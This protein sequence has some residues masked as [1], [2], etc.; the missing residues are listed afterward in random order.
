MGH[1]WEVFFEILIETIGQEV[2]GDW[3]KYLGSDR[4]GVFE[5]ALGKAGTAT[6]ETLVRDD[7]WSVSGAAWLTGEFA[8]VSQ[9][10]ANSDSEFGLLGLRTKLRHRYEDWVRGFHSSQFS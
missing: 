1:A 10:W 3:T 5:D 8:R 7:G 6:A 4:Q 2:D 9:D